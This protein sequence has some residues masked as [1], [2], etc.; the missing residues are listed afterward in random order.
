MK[1]VALGLLLI[2]GCY[3]SRAKPIHR[4][5][6]RIETHLSKDDFD[7]IF[8]DGYDYMIEYFGDEAPY[9]YE[10]YTVKSGYSIYRRKHE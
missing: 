2:S 3:E 7:I 1:W 6:L 5:V 9:G 4:Q 8:P 10:F